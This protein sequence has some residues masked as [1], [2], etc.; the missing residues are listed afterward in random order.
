MRDESLRDETRGE[1]ERFGS[2]DDE[3]RSRGE[4]RDETSETGVRGSEF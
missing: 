2:G 3:G 1:P 4:N